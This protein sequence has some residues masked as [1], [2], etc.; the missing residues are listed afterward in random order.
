MHHHKEFQKLLTKYM[1]DKPVFMTFGNN[2]CPHH[3]SAPYQ[4]EKEQFYNDIWDLW[5]VNHPG[6]KKFGTSEIKKTFM[7]GGY[8]R[9]DFSEKL[10][11]L[12][13]NSL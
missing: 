7:D 11:V 9:A 8:F 2:D 12:S 13:Y 5:F 1:P 4:F 3:D 6:N 10:T